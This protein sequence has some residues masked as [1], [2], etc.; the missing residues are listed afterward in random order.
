MTVVV[1]MGDDVK[2]VT[3]ILVLQLMTTTMIR[4]AMTGLM[5]VLLSV[6]CLL[7]FCRR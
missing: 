7:Y 6:S 4:T 1:V 3:H 5:I 2:A